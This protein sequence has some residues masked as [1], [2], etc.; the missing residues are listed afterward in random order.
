[1]TR[2]SKGGGLVSTWLDD[3]PADSAMLARHEADAADARLLAGIC[4]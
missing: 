2:E 1:M 3:L 4:S